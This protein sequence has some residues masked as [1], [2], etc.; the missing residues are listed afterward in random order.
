MAGI[1]VDAA[2]RAPDDFHDIQALVRAGFATLTE[3]SFLLLRVADAAAAR[4]WL[5][6]VKVTSAGDLGTKQDSVLQV[7]LTAA[8]MRALEIPEAVIAGFSAE[9]IAGLAA[10]PARNRRLGDVGPDAPQQWEWGWAEREPHVMVMLYALPGQLAALRDSLDGSD[11]AAGFV[12]LQ[13]LETSD[14]IGHEPVGFLDGVSQPT[15]DWAG[16]RKPDTD[17]DLEYGNLLTPGEFVLGYQNEYGLLTERP[18]LDTRQYPQATSLPPATEAAWLRDL[19]RNGS[20]LVMRTLRQDVRGFWRFM[21]AHGGDAF[22]QRVVGRQMDGTPL[23]P[24]QGAPIRGVGPDATDRAENQF[25]FS[26]DPNGLVCPIGAHIRRANPRTGD[27]PGGRMG[28]FGQLLC[29]AGFGGHTEADRVA[30]SRFHR[31]LRRGREYGTFMPAA[32]AQ[33][34]D[35]PDPEAGLHFICLAANISRQ[36]EFVQNAWL[37]SSKFAGLHGEADPLTGNRAPLADGKTTDAFGLPRAGIPAE[38]VM[39]MP[40]F[41]GVRGGAYFFLP[42]LRALRFLAGV[43]TAEAVAASA[44]W[45]E[46][47]SPAEEARIHAICA[48][49]GTYQRGFARRGDGQVHRGFH[50]KSHTGLRARFTV[51]DD[52]PPEAKHGVFKT[53]RTFDAL[54]RLSNGFSA[55][56]PDWFP[57]LVGCAVKLLGV[58]GT[59][60]LH[61]EEAAGS[62]DFVALNQPYLPAD[63]P[64][65]L[66]LISTAPANPLTAPF[67][68]VQGLGFAHTMQ[69]VWWALKWSL[70]RIPLGSVTTEDFYGLAPITIGPHAVKFKW[71]SRQMKLPRPP[72]ASWLNYLRDDLRRRLLAGDLHFDFMVQ[73]HVDPVSTPIDGAYAWDVPFVKLAELTIPSCDIDSYEAKADEH[74]LRDLSFNPWHAIEAHRPIG[75]IQRARRVVYQASAMLRARKADPPA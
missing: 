24:V 72:G 2:P 67:R 48:E 44:L 23:V 75:N 62:Q 15:I 13:T 56:M 50:V 10:D 25:T 21:A 11:F 6:A 34:P 1:A 53:A 41:I 16:Q 28:W 40:R 63:T 74:R 14:M 64:E 5:G 73:F 12:L 49:I 71:Q 17:A 37:Q 54:V 70:R 69:I 57:D 36:F 38:R 45:Q 35:G 66:T 30:A 19:G 20:Y 55:P 61:G 33:A 51:L 29:L 59:K 4:R 43:T 46:V 8:G 47:V 27:M 22:A 31:L 42:G 68:I 32:Q 9:F 26:G 3:A 18:L 7:A 39:D 60:L 52:I 65:Q 58:E